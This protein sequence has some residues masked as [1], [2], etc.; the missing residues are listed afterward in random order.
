[1]VSANNRAGCQDSV[2]KA[3]ATK[4]LKGQLRFGTWTEIQDHGSFRWKH[5]GCVSGKQIEGLRET[6][7]RGGDAFDF[8][9]IDGYDEMADYPDLQ[10]KIREAVE[11]GHIAPED[12]N[13]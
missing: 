4:C 6:C 11:Q 5:W 13:G 3:T 7:S 2:C 12:F 8:D 9:A 1:E 10:A